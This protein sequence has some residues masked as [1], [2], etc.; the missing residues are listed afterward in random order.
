MR[1]NTRIIG[2]QWGWLANRGEPE[3]RYVLVVAMYFI[4]LAADFGDRAAGMLVLPDARA[5]KFADCA[6]IIGLPAYHR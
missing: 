1:R 4:F 5:R 6:P 3:S 2:P